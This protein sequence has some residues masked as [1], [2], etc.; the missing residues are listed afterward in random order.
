MNASYTK[1]Q[2]IRENHTE[3]YYTNI[4]DMTPKVTKDWIKSLEQKR[5]NRKPNG[6]LGI[7]ELKNNVINK[8]DA[9]N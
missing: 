4:I 2:R 3:T 5:I 6:I 7:N 8:Y 1:L 9:P